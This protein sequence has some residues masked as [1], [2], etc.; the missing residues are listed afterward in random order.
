MHPYGSFRTIRHASAPIPFRFRFALHLHW[1]HSLYLFYS[2]FCLP[3][4]SWRFVC[5][6]VC[7]TNLNVIYSHSALQIN[8]IN[9]KR[10][11]FTLS[12]RIPAHSMKKP[13]PL[14][15]LPAE[16]FS[17]TNKKWHNAH[18]FGSH[19]TPRR[20]EPNRSK[21]QT[22]TSASTEFAW[23]KKNP[24][25]FKVEKRISI[26]SHMQCV[27]MQTLLWRAKYVAIMQSDC[28]T[29]VSVSVCVYAHYSAIFIS[30]QLCYYI[31]VCA[32]CA[33]NTFI[34]FHF[35]SFRSWL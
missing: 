12:R 19:W 20:T 7:D 32:R 34:W 5:C 15:I 25:N 14:V 18:R 30:I 31:V 33:L 1:I 13:F 9:V 27:L 4:C 6:A 8:K 3:K 16:K 26:Q 24:L 29:C 35:I 2:S 21:T 22:T 17:K 10:N 28:I 23:R 11:C